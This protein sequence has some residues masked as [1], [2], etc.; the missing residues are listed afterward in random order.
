MHLYTVLVFFF[1]AYF[2]LY[3]QLQFT[4]SSSQFCLFLA[5]LDLC[6]CE[7]FSLVVVSRGYSLFVVHGLLIAVA[8]LVAEHGIQAHQLQ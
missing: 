6:C 1:L 4:F 2:S 7:G 3:N 5:M 8:S